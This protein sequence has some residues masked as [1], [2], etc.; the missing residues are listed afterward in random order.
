MIKLKLIFYRNNLDMGGEM[1]YNTN[2]KD[3][4]GE[5]AEKALIQ[6]PKWVCLLH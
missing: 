3:Y 1:E 4:K 2:M 6:K 5:K